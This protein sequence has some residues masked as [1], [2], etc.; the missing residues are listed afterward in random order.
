MSRVMSLKFSEAAIIVI[1][2]ALFLALCLYQI[3]LPGLHYD[4]AREAGLP[5]MQLVLGQP[6][7]VFRGAGFRLLGQHLPFM[8]QDY[9]GAL[10]VYLAVPFLALLGV[11]VPA[12]RLMPVLCAALTLLFTYI[13]A[14]QLFNR[15][16]AA[17]AYLL[18]ALNPSFV[19]W[20]RQGIFVTSIT[21]T[22]AMASLVCALCWY[23]R[24]QDIYLYLGAFILGLGLYA[25]L[26]FAW[27]ILALL[28]AFVL[29]DLRR[30]L[31][32]RGLGRKQLALALL[33]FVSGLGPVVIYNLQTG[34]TF[35]TLVSNLTTSYYG[36]E[37]LAFFRNLG[38]R[39]TQFRVVL[40][41]GHL[42][43]LGGVFADRL[44]PYFFYG[45]LLAVVLIAHL[46]AGEDRGPALFPYLVIIFVIIA[47]CFT[48]SALWFTHYAL[49]T[50]WPP[51]AVAG[52]LDIL[53]RRGGLG[54]FGPL[55]ALGAAAMLGVADLRVDWQYHCALGQSGGLAAHSA[56]SYDLAVYLQE[57]NL[58]APVAMDW[59]IA[60]PVQFLTQG[61]VKPIEVFGYD[62]IRE[63]DE[64]FGPRLAAFLSNPDSVYIFH[65][66]EE[67]V[68]Q[69][70]Q[71]FEQLVTDRRK[72]SRE[73]A[74]IYRGENNGQPIF[75]LLR[76]ED[77][78]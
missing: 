36:T 70:R 56:A 47:S 8:V 57:R 64:G 43:Y 34:A 23:R 5:A 60:A 35:S 48:V 67:T 54:R 26:L 11:S 28:V 52:A 18:L 7:E 37:N 24:G 49:L 14:R 78:P 45:G 58:T 72:V 1:G 31:S 65:S 66:P 46:Q 32:Q 73:E 29:L 4:E 9:I 62:D 21:A 22:L 63:P 41:G 10:N 51:L 61:Q 6:L 3:A 39:L 50:P 16:V 55:V 12:L 33:C 44:W 53:A 15:R 2:L 59:G 20:N 25:K 76:V 77:Q 13:F 69:R 68:Y 40:E 38:D 17:I 42:W 75:I 74:I 27:F 71:T 30:L 19:F